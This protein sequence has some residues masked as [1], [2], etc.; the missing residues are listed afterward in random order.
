MKMSN[1]DR[2]VVEQLAAEKYDDWISGIR[3]ILQQPESPLSFNNGVWTVV[4]RREMWQVLGPRL[5][6]DHLDRFRQCVINV[7]RERDPQFELHSEERYAANIRGKVLKHSHALRKGLA[8]TLALLGSQPDAV[9]N[10][11]VGKAEAVAVIAVREILH[12]AD[13]VLWGSLDSLLPTLAEAAP[14]EFLSSV[15]S[16]L[17]KIPCPFDELFSQEGIG[18]FGANYMTGLLW[19]L[20]TLAW[21][22][23]YLVQAT[24]ILGKLASHDPGGNWGNRPDNSLITI[25]L[26][27]LPQTLASVEKR[28]VAIQTLQKESPSIAWRLLLDL[29]PKQHQSSMGS[30]KP[31]WRE[32]IP[33]NW[34][35][36]V[37]NDEY[38][39]QVSTYADL[40]VE[41]AEYEF[42]ILRELI[43]NL[44][45]LPKSSFDKL[46]D[47]L[48]SPNVVNSPEEERIVLW[49][50]L[51]GFITKH[52]RFK[53]AEW[54]LSPELIGKIEQ[55]ANSLVPQKPQN[56]YA[57]LFSDRTFDLYEER[58][59]WEDQ[60]KILEEKRKDA[61]REIISCFGPSAVLEFAKEVES[62]TRVGISLGLFADNGLDSMILP[63]LLETENKQ[64]A[65]FT[66]GFVWGKHRSKGFEWAR[67]IDTSRWS[68]AQIAKFLSC[69]PFKE[70][71]WK[72]AEDLLGDDE[73]KYWSIVDFNPYQAESGL[74]L[75]IEKLTEHSRPMAALRCV[76]ATLNL[77]KT[78]DNTQS[79]RAL[80]CAVSST[81]TP[82][83]IDAFEIV[84]IIK[85]LQDNPDTNQDDLFSIEWA[86]LPLLTG[87]GKSGSPKLL[88][89]RLATDPD[90]FC[91]AIRMLYKSKNETTSGKEP[92]E[93]KKLMAKNV[94]KLLTDWTTLPG[95]HIDGTF[96]ENDFNRWIER[97][98]T[99]C[100]RS[101]HLDVA[102]ITVGQVLI[103]Y[104]SDPSGLWIHRT[105]AEVLN[106][107]DAE[108][109]RKG[110]CTGIFNSRGV[111]CVDPTGKPEKELAA[112]Y[113][114]QAEELENARYYR[115]AISLKGLADSYEREAKRIIEEHESEEN[116]G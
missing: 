10:C 61:I 62:P 107:E 49:E 95:T 67:Q 84:E 79:V 86:Y 53:D 80:L 87:P 56:R 109:M 23:K 106:A 1:N 16:A 3:E 4:N 63:A 100:E 50:A 111:H 69:L 92:T 8:E 39:D 14:R 83:S 9:K 40:A 29:L 33:A 26:P 25:F 31:V 5:F 32:T 114:R 81:E 65:L 60:E 71:T 97:V 89:Q 18:I 112:K 51:L 48:G 52:K 116:S 54:A 15:E 24:V 58:G 74:A 21:D 105:L 55:V 57:R 93:Q 73:N 59:N 12:D 36:G 70:E 19:A 66:S 17:R 28:K 108:K 82:Y 2:Q 72:L 113:K 94:W 44:D 68:K 42:S 6:D 99:E 20:E 64:L 46:L 45:D 96:C 88:E 75:A 11:S 102:L 115:F 27:W 7:L 22:E 37:T 43:R 91:E 41:T 90:F 13:W 34:E 35:K 110:F 76:Y 85:F 101:G 30:H 103:H 104:I 78:L 98:K 38:W 77:N 47:N